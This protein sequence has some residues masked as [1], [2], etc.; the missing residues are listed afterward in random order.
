MD[1]ETLTA[2]L[3]DVKI[4]LHISWDD[5]ETNNRLQEY[6]LGSAAYLDSVM[7]QSCDYSQIGNLRTLL[8]ERVRYQ[9]SE[10]LDAW[11]NNYLS[12]VLAAQREVR[13][14]APES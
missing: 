10:A 2:L 11:L 7:G 6:I 12:L 8:M 3:A 1:N 4:Y 14:H 9:N 13:T 5:E